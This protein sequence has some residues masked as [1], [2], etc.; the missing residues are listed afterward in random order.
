MKL[1]KVLLR[2]GIWS[3]IFVGALNGQRKGEGA[4]E[5]TWGGDHVQLETTDDGGHLEFDCASGDLSAAIAPD[6]HGKFSVKGSY[7]AEHGGPTRNDESAAQ[8]T[9]RG[10]IHGET[11]ELEILDNAGKRVDRFTLTKSHYGRVMKCK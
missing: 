10:T 6:A 8:A 7:S 5:N 1:R 9:Y 3:L 2:L 11:M 4:P